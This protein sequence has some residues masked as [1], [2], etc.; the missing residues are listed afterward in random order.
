MVKAGHKHRPKKAPATTATTAPTVPISSMVDADGN[1]I[2]FELSTDPSN[3]GRNASGRS[4]KDRPQKRATS[5]IKTKINN[6]IKTWDERQQE[7][8]YRKEC[9][10]AQ[11]ELREDRR[12]GKILKK[13]RRSENEKRR[14]ENEF[15]QVQKS[16]KKLNLS[17]MGQTLKAMSKKQLRQIKKTRLNPKTG[18]VEY[19]PAYA[20]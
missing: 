15:Q 14:A 7:R 2:V 3:K 5:L 9:M 13:E 11:T 1:K 6:Q 8:L 16:A 10:E 17:K 20:K 18:V 4:W 12:Q 19:V